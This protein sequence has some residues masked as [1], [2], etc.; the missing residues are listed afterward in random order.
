L[1][2][3]FKNE[4][5]DMDDVV[6]L[7]NEDLKDIGVNKLKHRKLIMQET[8]KLGQGSS[9]PA[10][11]S[12]KQIEKEPEVEISRGKP[13]MLVISSTGGA[14]KL[15]G[16]FLG[17]FEYQEDED[18]YLQTSTDQSHE[19]FRARYLYHDEEQ[20]W[21]IS[22][23]RPGKKSG[24]MCHTRPNKDLPE[25][26]Y[27]QY[28]DGN[29]SWQHD[30]T[31]TISK[32]PLSLPRV[33]TVTG[34][35]AAAR[36][37][38]ECL[39]EFTRTQRWWAGRPVFGNGEGMLLHHGPGDYGWMIGRPLNRAALR[40]SQSHM[41]PSLQTNWLYLTDDGDGEWKRAKIKVTQSE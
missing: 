2:E 29:G 19:N 30:G 1:T 5:L 35:R 34:T 26:G 25:N 4:E 28:V 12:A 16:G 21:W 15:H 27:W 9:R 22:S 20:R 14:A 10:A 38:P 31:V 23:K 8:A 40:G 24:Y 17:Q 11:S 7:N 13:K 3:I 37:W 39:G 18:Y 41:S 36:E 32:G 6:N 33:F